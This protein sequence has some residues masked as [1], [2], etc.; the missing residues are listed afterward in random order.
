MLFEKLI[1]HVDSGKP[2]V[3][4]DSYFEKQPCQSII[5]KLQNA[6]L[7]IQFAN[8]SHA[9][10]W[11]VWGGNRSAV[12]AFS[13]LQTIKNKFANMVALNLAPYLIT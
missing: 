11:S 8:T 12:L 13:R 7:N 6:F 10:V 1:G 3:C 5:Y 9:L 4:R 2:N